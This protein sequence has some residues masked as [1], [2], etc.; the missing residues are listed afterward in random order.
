MGRRDQGGEYRVAIVRANQ[1]SIRR[2]RQPFSGTAQCTAARRLNAAAHV[3]D[4]TC[5]DDPHLHLFYLLSR[6]LTALP[7][8]GGRKF[9]TETARPLLLRAGHGRLPSD[10]RIFMPASKTARALSDAQIAQFIQ[11]GFVRIDRAFPREL[12]EQGRTILSRDLPCDPDDAATWTRPVIRLGYYS[13]EPF[14]KAV[15][16]PPAS[17][18]LRPARP[19]GAMAALRRPRHLPCAISKPARSRRHRL[20]CRSQLPRRESGY[21]QQGLRRLARQRHVPRPRAAD[22]VPLLRCARSRCADPDKPRLASGHGAPSRSGRRGRPVHLT[23]DPMGSDRP[24]AQATGEAGTVYLCHPFLIHAAQ[25][26]RGS[27]PRSMAQ[28]P[29]HPAEPFSLTVRTEI[30]RRL[31]EPSGRPCRRAHNP[32]TKLERG[33]HRARCRPAPVNPDARVARAHAIAFAAVAPRCRFHATFF[34]NR[35]I[36]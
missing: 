26:H 1:P 23:L 14:R 19:E 22:A 8:P 18:S 30:I 15:E 25:K 20:A 6:A 9:P 16:Q 24:E 11:D 7:A 31:S 36:R 12:A 5:H 17:Y 13:D 27:A 32:G 35:V 21:R 4:C 28:P 10:K 33:R 29:L 2:Q 34:A 3:I